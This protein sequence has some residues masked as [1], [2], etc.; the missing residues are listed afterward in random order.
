MDGVKFHSGQAKAGHGNFNVWQPDLEIIHGLKKRVP[1]TFSVVL[2]VYRICP[3]IYSMSRKAWRNMAMG[4]F[5]SRF[6]NFGTSKDDIDECRGLFREGFWLR[7]VSMDI[8]RD[9]RRLLCSR[10]GWI[11]HRRS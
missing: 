1:W 5:G 10:A 3:W 2:R 11:L 9:P 4:I 8:V 6:Y 7:Y